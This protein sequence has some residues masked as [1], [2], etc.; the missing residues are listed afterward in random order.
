MF[1][2]LGSKFAIGVVQLKTCCGFEENT[3]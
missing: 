2:F 1:T 3:N